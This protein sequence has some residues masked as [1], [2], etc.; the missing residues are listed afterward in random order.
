M[1]ENRKIPVKIKIL[2]IHRPILDPDDKS[3][4]PEETEELAYGFLSKRGGTIFLVYE[5][6]ENDG[7]S[8]KNMIKFTPKPCELKKTSSFHKGTITTPASNLS[9]LSGASAKGFYTTPYGRLD[10]ETITQDLKYTESE[11][12]F[13][14][15]LS[16]IMKINNSPVSEFELKIEADIL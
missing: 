15:T 4:V 7:T 14:C 5:I 16:G 1:D 11:S 2:G 13:S 6:S 8:I 12:S 3:Q 10:T 9:Y